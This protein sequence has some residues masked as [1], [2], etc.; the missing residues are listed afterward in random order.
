MDDLPADF[1]ARFPSLRMIYGDLS[2]AIHKT[3][4][5]EELFKRVLID[6][7]AHFDAKR[8]YRL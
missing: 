8:L 1:M 4:A 6:T 2:D 3:D 5:S 7:D